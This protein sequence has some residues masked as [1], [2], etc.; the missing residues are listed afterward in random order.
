LV[1]VNSLVYAFLDLVVAKEDD[2]NNSNT[3]NTVETDKDSSLST[4][5]THPNALMDDSEFQVYLGFFLW[6]T[7]VVT[8]LGL[9][10]VA[11]LMFLPAKWTG[12]LQSYWILAQSAFA[13]FTATGVGMAASRNYAALLVFVAGMWKFGFPQTSIFMF[14][15]L[16]DTSLSR[17][18]RIGFFINAIG[19]ITHHAAASLCVAM[20]LT[21]VIT[22]VNARVVFDI[23]AIAMMQH[24]FFF[25]RYVNKKTY[26]AVE[27][28]LET[29]FEWITLSNLEALFDNHWTAALFGGTFLFSHWLFLA[30]GTID[31]FVEK[32]IPMLEQLTELPKDGDRHQCSA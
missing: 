15:A 7:I 19:L 28:I 3:D 17:L 1:L 2:T 5:D 26:V 25:L 6:G 20:A 18:T 32:T 29:W 13:V 9:E 23:V 12:K 27:I 24:W 31:L 22:N 30:A 21:G 16:N 10:F 4:T 14:L 8:G 11:F